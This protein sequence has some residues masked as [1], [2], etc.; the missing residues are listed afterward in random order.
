MIKVYMACTDAF[1]R[2]ELFLQGCRE[3]DSVRLAK[4]EACKTAEDKARS[5]CCGLLLQYVLRTYEK[6]A[7]RTEIRYGYGKYGKPYLQDYPALH[8]SLSHSGSYAVLALADR[9]GGA[10][11]QIIRPLREGVIRRT[12]SEAEYM[13]YERLPLAAEKQDWFFRCWCAKESYVKL[14]GEGFGREFRAISLKPGGRRI[15][16]GALCREY[17]P[18]AACFLNVC[19]YEADGDPGFPQTVTDITQPLCGMVAAG[20][21]R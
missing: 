8:I 3:I 21:G 6:A 4:V 16:P 15:Q 17:C 13:I 9:E 1:R 12:L 20:S 2:Q 19:V 14:T 18:G 7:A 11:V 5:L 10:D